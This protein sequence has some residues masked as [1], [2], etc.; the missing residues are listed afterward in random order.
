MQFRND[1]GTPVDPVPFFV[2]AGTAFAGCYS[3]GPAYFR[4]LG[5]ALP[6]AVGVS[7][8]VFLGTVVVS[9]HQLVWTA[10]PERRGEVP[11]EQ[12][13]RKFVLGTLIGIAV[14]VLLSLPLLAG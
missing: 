5:L 9:Y 8:A 3:F 12:R 7:T 13:L 14:V 4:A 6:L 10:R 1:R 2:T 11:V